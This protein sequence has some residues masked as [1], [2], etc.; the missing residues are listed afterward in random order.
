MSPDSEVEKM[1]KNRADPLR[2]RWT[3]ALAAVLFAALAVVV[4]SVDA[5]GDA[6][7]TGQDA[8]Y[9]STSNPYN[10]MHVHWNELEAGSYY[11]LE[12]GSLVVI[13]FEGL[14]MPRLV[15]DVDNSGL[16]II[17]EDQCLIGYL[18][19]NVRVSDGDKNVFLVASDVIVY[20]SLP[21]YQATPERGTA[22]SPLTSLEFGANY[23]S[24]TFIIKPNSTVSITKYDY[25]AIHYAITHVDKGFG[26]SVSDGGLSGTIFKEGVIHVTAEYTRDISSKRSYSYEYTATIYVTNGGTEVSSISIAAPSSVDMG[27]SIQLNATLSPTNASVK[28][29]NWTVNNSEGVVAGYIGDDYSEF[30][31]I[32]VQAGT[33]TVTATA[34]DGSGKTQSRTIEVV[35]KEITTQTI[36]L[37]EHTADTSNRVELDPDAD[38]V[39]FDGVYDS[40]STSS[41]SLSL[42]SPP[43]EF[44]NINTYAEACRFVFKP[45][46]GVYELTWVF[47]EIMT[48]QA[49]TGTLTVEVS[50]KISF[51]ANSGRFNDGTSVQTKTVRDTIA[52]PSVAH[53]SMT[54]LGWYD[55]KDGGNYLGMAGVNYIPTSSTTLYAH[56]GNASLELS[57][58]FEWQGNDGGILNYTPEVT[59]SVTGEP[60]YDFKV[61]LVDDA[62]DCLESAGSSITGR[63][64]NLIPG[65]YE[66]TIRVSKLNYESAL[67]TVRITIPV[68]ALEPLTDTAIVGERWTTTLV[69]KPDDAYI[70]SYS[71]KLGD[72]VTTQYVARKSG[73]TFEITCEEEG[74]YTIS[75]TLSAAGISSSIKT[76]TLNATPPEIH[77]EPPKISG[78]RA[79]KNTEPTNP[80]TWYFTA[81]GVANYDTLTWDFGDGSTGT[82]V[83]A[84]HKFSMGSYTVTCTVRNVTTGESASATYSLEALDKSTIDASDVINIGSPYIPDGVLYGSQMILTVT[85]Q[86]GNE[87]PFFTGTNEPYSKGYILKISGTI[88]D[89]SY[90]GKTLSFVVKSGSTVIKTWTAKVYPAASSVDIGARPSFTP[91]ANGLDVSL[92]RINP[93]ANYI[94]LLVDWGDGDVDSS[95]ASGTFEHTYPSAGRY[96]ISMLWTWTDSTGVAHQREAS[97][98]VTVTQSPPVVPDEI[99][100]TYMPNGGVGEM[101]EQKGYPPFTLLEPSFEREG[102][103]F[104]CWST[105]EDPMKGT[106]Y[107]PGD[108]LYPNDSMT[109]YAI[110]AEDGRSDDD[111]LRYVVVTVLL[112]V[113]LGVVVSRWI[114]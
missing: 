9:G 82:G 112:V 108:E 92:T 78:I 79:T 33:V 45:V 31:V 71:V 61:T 43:K 15:L 17:E 40:S 81:V 64:V 5:D 100:I 48:G 47:S 41:T 51:D 67:Q 50:Y 107:Y 99:V 52:L 103:S 22:K 84:I 66:A 85:D 1:E 62:T 76:I 98:Q 87:V 14:S 55:A 10:G 58:T 3:L 89:T 104:V 18:D 2:S 6:G 29:L 83:E 39:F 94:R 60:V 21:V 109:L 91:V 20:G 75:L 4:P 44:V 73:S 77:D 42:Q 27:G 12:E 69:L 11:I 80:N 59:D 16:E 23:L 86:S 97:G 26:L 34:I 96:P 37:S 113:V 74:I 106:I 54:F 102:H 88:S 56:W 110:W 8:V 13:S 24:G 30:I 95:A 49:Q 35:E 90:V 19:A 25:N 57:S 28:G 7:G 114:L 72:S 101:A 32:G 38:L 68:T 46:A 93:N 53:P 36:K 63:I 70:E 105:S 111:H 65:T